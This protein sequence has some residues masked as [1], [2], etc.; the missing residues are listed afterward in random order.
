MYFVKMLIDP[1]PVVIFFLI[2]PMNAGAY[3][4]L[5]T[6]LGYALLAVRRRH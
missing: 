2:A 1:S 4:A 5:G 6:A 3:G